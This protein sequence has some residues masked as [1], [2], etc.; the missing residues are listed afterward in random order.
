MASMFDF[1]GLITYD[2]PKW[3]DIKPELRKLWSFYMV[4]RVLSM[5]RDYIELCNFTQ[6]LSNL[7]KHLQY[8]FLCEM[9]PKKK[10]W[11]PY[12]K[13]KTEKKYSPEFLDVLTTYYECSSKE[14]Q[15]YLL[16]LSIDETIHIF[17]QIGV[18]DK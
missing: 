2:K 15:D 12:I 13:N 16:I 18:N 7:P 1:I 6:Q 17:N 5:N 3:D 11:A 9:T 10:A 8:R 14:V 4:N